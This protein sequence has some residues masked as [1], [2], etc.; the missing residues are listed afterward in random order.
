MKKTLII[1][2]PKTL[3]RIVS[4]VLIIKTELCKNLGLESTFKRKL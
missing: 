2:R 1:F 4:F 3:D